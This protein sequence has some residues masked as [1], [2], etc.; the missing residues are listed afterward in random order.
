LLEDIRRNHEALAAELGSRITPQDRSEWAKETI[1]DWVMEDHRLARRVAYG[2]LG[3]GNSTLI[4]AAHEGQAD[5]VV[6]L[7]LEKAGVR[8]AYPPVTGSRQ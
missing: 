4:T 5:P 6:E 2:D 7:Q 1:G 8:L 3:T